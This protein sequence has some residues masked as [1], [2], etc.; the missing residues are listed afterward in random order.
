MCLPRIPATAILDI[1]GYFDSY[2]D[3]SAL[4]YYSLTP[5]RVT[6]TTPQCNRIAGRSVAASKPGALVPDRLQRLQNPRQRV[7]LFVNPHCDSAGSAEL[8]ERRAFALQSDAVPHCRHA[9]PAGDTS[10]H[11]DCHRNSDRSG[12]RCAAGSPIADPERYSSSV[13][14]AE[15]PFV[16]ANGGL[17]LVVSTLN[18]LDGSITSNR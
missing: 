8:S 1:N 18:A 7:G 15:P 12:L 9:E 3:S 17:Q 4:Q 10:L 5:C 16:M 14:S 11:R 6:L 13:G 2:K